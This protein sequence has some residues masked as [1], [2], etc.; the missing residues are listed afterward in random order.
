MKTISKRLDLERKKVTQESYDMLEA[1][2]LVK[3]TASA[4]FVESVEAHISLNIDPKYAD[5]QL[6]TT[7]VLPKGTGKSIRIAVLCSEDK[8]NEAL[9][10]GADIAGNEALIEDIGKGILNFELLVATPDMMPKLAKLG[11]VLGPKGLMPSPKAGTVSVNLNETI[12]DFKGGKLEYRADKTGIVHINFGKADFSVE[13]LLENLQSF[14]NSI[15][16]NKPTG[17]KG[18]YIKKFT[19]CSTMGPGVGI[20]FSMF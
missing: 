17:V 5:Q 9:T 3:S 1:I 10:A 12:G 11:R 4:K 15:E 6:R 19:I 2:K 18:K 8:V 20:D 7:V 14:Y 16:K 13:D